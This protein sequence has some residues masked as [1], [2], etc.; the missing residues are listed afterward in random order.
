MRTAV[1]IELP[2]VNNSCS[3]ITKEKGKEFI[4]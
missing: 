4:N 2:K 1:E 3:D